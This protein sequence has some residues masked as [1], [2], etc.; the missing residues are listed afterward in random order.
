MLAAP[1]FRGRCL[2][3]PTLTSNAPFVAAWPFVVAFV[4][5]FVVVAVVAFVA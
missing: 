1:G 2:V 5:V 4:A 3:V